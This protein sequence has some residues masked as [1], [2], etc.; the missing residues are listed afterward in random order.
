MFP[1]G[2]LWIPNKFYPDFYNSFL[3]GPKRQI[4]IT[5]KNMQNKFSPLNIALNE[6]NQKLTSSGINSEEVN[7]DDKQIFI[8][9]Q[10]IM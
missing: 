4:R 8:R 5:T 10:I 2:S 1:G 7:C 6:F 3:S 9:I